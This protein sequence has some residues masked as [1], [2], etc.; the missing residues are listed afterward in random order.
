[1]SWRL[2]DVYT[3]HDFYQEK[4]YPTLHSLLVAVKEKGVFT[5][6]HTTLWRVVCKIGFKHKKVNN[7]QYISH[8][9]NL[10]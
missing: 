9:S 1:M 8:M 5:G 10:V 3:V 7:N 6:E 2:C 4:K